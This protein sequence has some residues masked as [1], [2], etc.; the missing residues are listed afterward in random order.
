MVLTILHIVR[1]KTCLTKL[2]PLLK[3]FSSR[4]YFDTKDDFIEYLNRHRY[5]LDTKPTSQQSELEFYTLLIDKFSQW[6][7]TAIT[8]AS[9]GTVWKQLVSL[10][11]SDT[12]MQ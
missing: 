10:Q 1:A 12:L 5:E 11:V 2:N 6:F 3:P 8:E 7:F 4:W 9:T